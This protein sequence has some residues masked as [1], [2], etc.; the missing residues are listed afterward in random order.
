MNRPDAAQ[1]RASRGRGQPCARFVAIGLGTLA[2]ACGAGLSI[3]QP[4]AQPS[5]EAASP[6]RTLLPGPAPGLD[7]PSPWRVLL[8]FV[9]MVAV[10]FAFVHLLKRYGP[11]GMARRL[12]SQDSRGGRIRLV[13][14]LRLPRSDKTLYLL[15]ADGQRVLLA[16]GRQGSALAVLPGGAALGA[17]VGAAVSD[18]ATTPLAG[19]EV[20]PG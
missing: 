15:E 6:T 1:R 10:A 12:A 20:P 14:T 13:D 4:S 7:L 11:A 16:E 18:A 5:A 17:T 2:G 8:V 19:V 9:L 3:A